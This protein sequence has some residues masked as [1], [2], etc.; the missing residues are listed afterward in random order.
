MRVA[1]VLSPVTENPEPEIESELMVTGAVPLEVTV[2][3]L[4][5]AVPIDTLPN[6]REVALRVRPGTEAFN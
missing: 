2:M 3:D 5:T 1:G 4:E 6:E